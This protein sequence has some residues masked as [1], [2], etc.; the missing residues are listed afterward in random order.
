[1]SGRHA[2]ASAFSEY[3]ETWSAVG[4]VVP[5]RGEEPAAE[6]RLGREADRVQHA[7]EP[8]ADA[9][10]RATRGAPASVTSSSTISTGFGQPA[11]GALR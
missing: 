6:A 3:A 4:D 1:M 10:A 8:A 11:R 7:V 5:R 9:L 2:T